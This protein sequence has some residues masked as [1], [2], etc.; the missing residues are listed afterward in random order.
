MQPR[1]DQAR[2]TPAR[3]ACLW[4]MALSCALLLV[5]VPRV[6]AD[7]Q[8]GPGTAAAHWVGTWAA[9]PQLT[10]ERN[11]PPAPGFSDVT[12]RQ[13]LHVSIGGSRLRVR[14]SNAFGPTPLRI[15]AAHLARS[16]GASAIEPA[17]DR[18]LTFS[19]RVS[20][21][22]PEGGQMVSDPLDFEVPPLS[23]LTV[24]VYLKS[25]PA[26]VTGHPGSR[27][28]SYLQKGDVVAAAS[29][30]DAVPVDHW[31]FVN[32]ID[33]VAGEGAATLAVLGDSI[34]DGR[35]S[36][37]NGNDRWPDDLAR[38]LHADKRTAQ[39]AIVNHGIGGNRLLRDGLGPNVLARLDR[40]IIA[41]PG[42][43]W[44]IVLEGIN[45]IGTAAGARAK[46]EPAATADDIVAAYEQII[47]RAHTRGIRVY[48]A[49]ILPFE[50]SFYFS[51]QGEA[52]RQKVNEW[53]RTSGQFDAVI[54]FDA[55]TRDA[56]HPTFLSAAVDG[57]D[58]LHPSAVGYKIMAD[59]I[60][61]G[62]FHDPAP[63]HAPTSMTQR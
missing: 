51:S 6:W 17:T 39:V 36:T 43:R 40:D 61:L 14:F 57:G 12:L 37:T 20:T 25:S 13:V 3:R 8:A 41:Q 9:S 55:L 27:T 35:G 52:D 56:E 15:V 49:T 59:A 53:I 16:A 48:G 5:G 1:S 10:E 22:I 42:I 30:P 19:G 4:T 21:I 44:L 46:G 34:T 24:S 45:D 58:H 62:L 50:G 32:G 18:T 47:V 63:D 26:G 7:P 60:D 11:L 33:V 31:Y 29:L 38:R 54:D 28:T 23:S 2:H